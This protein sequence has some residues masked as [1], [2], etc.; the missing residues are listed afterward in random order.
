MRLAFV[1]LLC[2]LDSL[3]QTC[4]SVVGRVDARAT[5]N[6]W[7]YQLAASTYT[8]SNYFTRNPTTG[9]TRTCYSQ[10]GNNN[11]IASQELPNCSP[12][13][14]PPA[15]SPPP[16]S[17][18]PPAPTAAVQPCDGSQD[19]AWFAA[20]D[21]AATERTLCGGDMNYPETLVSEVCPA[22]CASSAPPSGPMCT[23]T[24]TP[25]PGGCSPGTSTSCG[26][27]SGCYWEATTNMC[28][29]I[30]ACEYVPIASCESVPGCSTASPP[31]P[32]AGSSG[33][34]YCTPPAQASAAMQ[35]NP[36]M[37]SGAP[38]CTWTGTAMP[39]PEP[40]PTSGSCY[41]TPPAQA[42][43]AMQA[44]P[45]MCSGAPDCTWTGTMTPPPSPPPPS[46]TCRCTPPAQASVSMQANPT[47]CNSAPGC[48]WAGPMTP[49]PPPPST[50][51]GQC[52]CTPPAQAAVSMQA[53]PT[54]C[55]SAPGCSWTGLM[56]M[57]PPAP[58]GAAPFMNE[59]TGG[60]VISAVTAVFGVSQYLLQGS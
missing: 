11:C 54:A 40:M 6:K 33:S 51:T 10:S 38:D 4:D 37:C 48:S 19:C 5:L 56:P 50:T 36:A 32:T 57:T 24:V 44:N 35:A 41:C 7:C 29:D 16:P 15:P 34:C 26:T 18:S 25:Y 46:A 43:A 27:M 14:P 53:N 60:L 58:P 31:A 45:A 17:P 1:L 12:P 23:G 47:A 2:P 42:S 39:S 59:A 20:R 21:C 3:A 13:P 28:T 9:S 30:T 52:T 55:N 22:E 8:C 49:P